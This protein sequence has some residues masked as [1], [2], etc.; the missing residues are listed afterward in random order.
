M[1]KR[2]DNF[3]FPNPNYFLTGFTLSS[4]HSMLEYGL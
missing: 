4:Y 3:S 2:S 1:L